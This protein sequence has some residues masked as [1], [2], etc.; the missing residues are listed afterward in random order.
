M[1]SLEE[2]T[3]PGHSSNGPPLSIPALVVQAGLTQLKDKSRS[4]SGVQLLASL[5]VTLFAAPLTKPVIVSIDPTNVP[6][7]VR[8]VPLFCAASITTVAVYVLPVP[9]QLKLGI[10]TTSSLTATTSKVKAGL[11]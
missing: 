3:S 4:C 8:I 2:S 10:P 1:A 11:A 5:M 7:E 9:A 6:R